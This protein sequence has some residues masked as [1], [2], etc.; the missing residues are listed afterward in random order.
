MCNP[1]S[2]RSVLSFVQNLKMRRM[3]MIVKDRIEKELLQ[4]GPFSITT[5]N[6]IID[7]M[8]GGSK[9][10][11]KWMHTKFNPADSVVDTIS[12]IEHFG[13]TCRWT[14]KCEKPGLI[15]VA[16]LESNEPVFAYSP[17]RALLLAL[18]K[19]FNA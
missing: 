6:N 15:Y 7:Q 3:P 2:K 10:P 11:I 9:W 12:L 16:Q 14:L 18:W 13:P 4:E 1:F 5:E 17:S 8:I 19:R